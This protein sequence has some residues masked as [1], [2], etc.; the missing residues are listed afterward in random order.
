[1]ADKSETEKQ[2]KPSSKFIIG[3]GKVVSGISFVAGSV[4]TAIGA[5]S[6]DSR[7]GKAEKIGAIVQGALMTAAGALGWATAS[8]ASRAKSFVEAEQAKEQLV[9][10]AQNYAE[11]SQSR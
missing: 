1:M 7:L 3:A 10:A 5:M 11:K 8:G 2:L 4:I 6:K 9:D